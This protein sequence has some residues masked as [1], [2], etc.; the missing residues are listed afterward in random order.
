[1]GEASI[2]LQIDHYSKVLRCLGNERTFLSL[3]KQ[4]V[5]F[6]GLIE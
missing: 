4:V 2:T 5:K 6:L 3:I 1:M